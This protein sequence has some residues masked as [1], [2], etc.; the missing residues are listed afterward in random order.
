MSD[1]GDFENFDHDDGSRDAG[2]SATGGDAA[3]DDFEE[4][5][6]VPVGAD[7][8]IGTLSASEGLVVSESA[9]DTRL[10]AY[11]TVDNRS[12]VRVGHYLVAPYPDEELLFCR[13][14]ALEYAQEFRSDDATEIH[15]RRAM[16]RSGIDEEDYKFIA[17]LEPVAVLYSDAGELKRRMPDRVPKPE[18]VVRQAEDSAEIKTGLKIPGEGVFLGHLSVG[19]ETV[20]TAA[21]PPTIDYRLKDD[22]ADGDPLVFRDRKSVV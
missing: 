11:V 6:A 13:I 7:R 12:A 5:S 14:V 21:E 20:R 3:D 22:Y 8:G 18:A 10:R 4:V 19:G 1:L 17:T 9:D 2:D 15:A 16:R